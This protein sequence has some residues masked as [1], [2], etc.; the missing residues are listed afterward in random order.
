LPS[1]ELFIIVYLG[2]TSRE[3]CGGIQ[4]QHSLKCNAASDRLYDGDELWL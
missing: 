4:Q 1:I 3:F 2:K